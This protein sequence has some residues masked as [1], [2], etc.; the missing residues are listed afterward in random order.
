MRQRGTQRG[1][2]HAIALRLSSVLL[3]TAPL[4]AKN[5]HLVS[6]AIADAQAPA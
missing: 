3:F 1:R 2:R 6:A 5:R 4:T